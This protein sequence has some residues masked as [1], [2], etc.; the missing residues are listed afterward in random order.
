MKGEITMEAQ[1]KRLVVGPFIRRRREQLGMTQLQMGKALRHRYGNFVGMIEKGQSPFPMEHWKEY[2]DILQVPRHE[3]LKVVL[4]DLYPDTLE[5][6]KFEPPTPRAETKK[7][8]PE[9]SE[10]YASA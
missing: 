6:L 8:G 5:Y 9:D 2:A 4:E 3:F 7:A 1:T 10:W